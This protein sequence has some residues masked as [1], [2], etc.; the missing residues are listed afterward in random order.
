MSG[1]LSVRASAQAVPSL[2]VGRLDDEAANALL[3]LVAD[4]VRVA[5]CAGH[6]RA[7][8]DRCGL[9]LDIDAR[10]A[11]QHAEAGVDRRLAWLDHL[12]ELRVD[13]GAAAVALL[14]AGIVVWKPPARHG[15]ARGAAPETLETDEASADAE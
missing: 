1:R 14:S 15:A 3:T 5:G 12:A 9:A 6:E 8:R 4:R 11:L 10:C 13:L 2:G 7:P